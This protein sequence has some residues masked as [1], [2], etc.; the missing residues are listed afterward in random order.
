MVAAAQQPRSPGKLEEV[1]V[2]FFEEIICIEIDSY[3]IE[4]KNINFSYHVVFRRIDETM[5][6][7]RKDWFIGNC[8]EEISE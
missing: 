5:N 7:E 3:S 8:F 1:E 6:F 4:M 2:L